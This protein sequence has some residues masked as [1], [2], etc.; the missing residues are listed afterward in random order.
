MTATHDRS[1]PE[2]GPTEAQVTVPDRE[3]GPN[4]RALH[5]LD[6]ILAQD[7]DG[8][9]TAWERFK[10]AIDEDRRDGRTLFA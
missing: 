7:P 3:R 9:C 2:R 4:L 8:Q 10:D 5:V 1:Q 6:K